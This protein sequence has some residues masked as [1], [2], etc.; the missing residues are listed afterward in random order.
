MPNE[1]EWERDKMTALKSLLMLTLGEGRGK[2]GINLF[3]TC[4]C[5]TAHER[6]QLEE[7]LQVAGCYTT[8]NLLF[9]VFSI[10]GLLIII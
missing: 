6:H 2:E 10:Y 5:N 9:I 8:G 3:L 7:Y 4:K 1:S